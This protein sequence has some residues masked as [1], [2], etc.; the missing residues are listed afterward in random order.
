[1]SLETEL[2]VDF[3]FSAF[4]EERESTYHEPGTGVTINCSVI[5]TDLPLEYR[6]NFDG[7]IAETVHAVAIRKSD[8]E[9]PQREAKIVIRGKWYRLE[10]RIEDT[11][12]LSRWV[13]RFVG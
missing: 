7:L 3:Y 12:N 8:I 6:P 10:K 1:M 9:S 11:E 4:G 2:M 5:F 13:I